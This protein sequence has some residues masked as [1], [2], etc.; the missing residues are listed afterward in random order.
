MVA[1]V[2]RGRVVKPSV[3]GSRLGPGFDR[4]FKRACHPDPAARFPTAGDQVEELAGVL[5][6]A[7]L[8]VEA[9][10][11][12]AQG[13]ES[14]PTVEI[15]G[16]IGPLVRLGGAR[17]WWAGAGLGAIVAAAFVGALVLGR[18][19]RQAGASAPPRTGARSGNR[20]RNG[21]DDFFRCEHSLQR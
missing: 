15:E 4:W 14:A 16:Q 8:P 17:T 21:S 6:I 13:L 11:D 1:D 5:G 20:V 2:M 10:E 7:Q 18:A 3:R 12:D 9:S 19:Q